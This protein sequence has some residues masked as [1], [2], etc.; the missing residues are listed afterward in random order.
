KNCLRCH[1]GLLLVVL[2]V[3][4]CNEAPSSVGGQGSPESLAVVQV[5]TPQRHTIGRTVSQPGYIQAFE[6]TPIFAKVPGY[7][8]KWHVAIGDEVHKDELLAELWVPE[9]VS[10]LKV[11]EEQVKQAT[12][13]LAM[14][15]AQVLTAKAQVKEA[16][17]AFSRAE[18]VNDYWKG[19]NERFAKLV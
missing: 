18:A 13:T 11:K 14:S 8:L 12:K 3:V 9:L 10:E 19:Q 6:Q 7:V 5:V 2:G 1:F 4:G 16:E 17:A 15:Q